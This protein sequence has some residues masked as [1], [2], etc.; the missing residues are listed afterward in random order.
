MEG[1]EIVCQ[2]CLSVIMANTSILRK[3]QNFMKYKFIPIHYG[4]FWDVPDSFLTQYKSK[5][6]LFT[7]YGFDEELDDYPPNYE[8]YI[9]ENI[10]L[11]NAVKRNLWYPYNYDQKIF[12]GEIPT[13]DVIFD[14]TM[15]EFVNTAVFDMIRSAEKKH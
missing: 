7:R 11:E 12:I 2:G 1:K 9:V 15:K 5:V 4:G 10:S 13:K 3:L 6:Y 8:V 14:W